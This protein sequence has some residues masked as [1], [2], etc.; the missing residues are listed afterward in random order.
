MLGDPI[1]AVFTASLVALAYLLCNVYEQEII[2]FLTKPRF[3]FPHSRHVDR[4][5][6]L[7]PSENRPFGLSAIVAPVLILPDS[8]VAL[9]PV[10]PDAATTESAAPETVFPVS[11]AASSIVPDPAVPDPSSPDSVSD[12]DSGSLPVPVPNSADDAPP[13]PVDDGS[14]D[15][16]IPPDP[17][18]TDGISPPL[19]DEGSVEAPNPAVPTTTVEILPPPA[20]AVSLPPI[21]TVTVSLPSP[22]SLSVSQL[23]LTSLTV[24]SSP[25]STTSDSSES[26]T[27]P[28]TPNPTGTIPHSPGVDEYHLY[29]GNGSVAAGWPHKADWVSYEDMFTANVPLISSSCTIYQVALDTPD[30]IAGLRNATLSISTETNTDPRFILAV[31]M[32]ESNGCV[33]VPTSYYSV[34][35]PGL[36]Q[37]HNGPATCNE[38]A[39]PMYPC[40]YAT[41]EEMIREGTAG[42]SWDT[43][44][45][46]VEALRQATG[47]VDDVGRYYRAARIY[48]S[49]SVDASENLEAGIATHCYASDVA[50]RLTGWVLAKD[51]CDGGGL[52]ILPWGRRGL[53]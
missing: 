25:T 1:A 41:I 43:G 15:T 14:N 5:V 49:G 23:S 4:T 45:G 19:V 36:M 42:T 39:T 29:T 26:S 47:G 50:N 6:Q 12:A 33:R 51:E 3:H 9:D 40:P 8:A 38:D 44:L 13:P 53:L 7:H 24:S 35:N 52:R 17:T 11:A 2:A 27:L 21:T 20:P 18:A 30:E 46:L 10:Q 31:I 28:A 37:S 34:R 16:A 22:T 32:Q 48:N